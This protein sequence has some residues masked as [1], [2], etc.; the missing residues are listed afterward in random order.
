MN[1]DFNDRIQLFVMLLFAIGGYMLNKYTS[2][3][4]DDYEN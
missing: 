3:K 4:Y 1:L 2:K